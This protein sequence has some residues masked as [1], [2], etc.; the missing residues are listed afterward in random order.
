MVVLVNHKILRQQ[1]SNRDID[2]VKA[3]TTIT[4]GAGDPGL[5]IQNSATA[6]SPILLVGTVTHTAKSIGMAQQVQR[7]FEGQLE[8]RVA[9]SGFGDYWA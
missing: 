4:T 6:K 5:S 1:D 8:Q 3:G 7:L 2:I 9:T